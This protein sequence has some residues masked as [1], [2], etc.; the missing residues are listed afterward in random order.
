MMDGKKLKR[1]WTSEEDE[2]LRTL[3]KEHGSSNWTLIA[4]KLDNRTGKQCRERYSNH[5]VPNVKKG[6][7]T[8]EED[9][10]IFTMQ[11]KVGNQWAQI[12]KHLP[13]RTDNSVKNR[14]HAVQRSK[15]YKQSSSSSEYSQS[16]F[17]SPRSPADL[18]MCEEQH[19]CN[20]ALLLQTP[21]PTTTAYVSSLDTQEKT[22]Q[23]MK[24]NGGLPMNFSIQDIPKSSYAKR[25]HISDTNVT[26][27]AHV[28]HSKKRKKE[29]NFSELQMTISS[30]PTLIAH[31]PYSSHVFSPRRKGGG[32]FND[33][34]DAV[35][36]SICK[37][38]DITVPTHFESTNLFT[39]SIRSNS[40]SL[41]YDSQ[42]RPV[43]KWKSDLV[44]ACNLERMRKDQ[45]WC[46]VNANRVADLKS[47]TSISQFSRVNESTNRLVHEMK[48][49][50]QEILNN[51]DRQ[52][53][54]FPGNTILET[55]GGVMED[56]FVVRHRNDGAAND[57][58][59]WHNDST[60]TTSSSRSSSTISDCHS[61][62]DLDTYE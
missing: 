48:K 4:T 29:G 15:A 39:P 11:A 45:S 51:K 8:E 34:D 47:F 49:A 41:H 26:S 6:P 22:Q 16:P 17:E 33:K 21:I 44:H 53:S 59:S 52:T 18:E 2:A 36:S 24:I 55:D 30:T 31:T 3:V 58:F 10:I 20:Q 40:G 27:S 54:I 42:T 5:L 62:H 1:M 50:D 23:A 28:P 12:T 38:I 25:S 7:W 37:I 13:G 19:D 46:A 57:D 32:Y 56:L 14:W 61:N 60:S 9:R 43:R 35:G